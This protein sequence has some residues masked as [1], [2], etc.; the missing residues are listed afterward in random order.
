MGDTADSLLADGYATHAQLL[1]RVRADVVEADVAATRRALVEHCRMWLT[2]DPEPRLRFAAMRPEDLAGLMR[3]APRLTVLFTQAAMYPN[4]PLKRE[5]GFE[6]TSWEPVLASSRRLQLAKLLLPALPAELPVS[7]LLW[8]YELRRT[9]SALRHLKG[10]WEGLVRERLSRL[11]RCQ[12]TK[13]RPLRAGSA[14]QRFE[15]DAVVW[16]GEP[17]ANI[18]AL[19]DA[20]GRPALL[21]DIKRIEGQDFSIRA[22][23]MLA[24]AENCKAR[25]PSLPVAA[26]LYHPHLD[27][28]ERIR[29]RLTA[30][31]FDAVVFASEAPESI[32][33]ALVDVLRICAPGL[34]GAGQRPTPPARPPARTFEQG[35][36]FRRMAC[37]HK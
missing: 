22:G 18:N 29:Y 37:P 24:A 31:E 1:D 13:E 14:T 20:D 7:A 30:G 6:L 2:D 12:V 5:L 34:L 35:T 25:F 3:A 28:H 8:M 27:K 15:I 11:T 26:V 36:L 17:A 33:D 32:D 19:T 4:R 9:E 21:V 16:R 23:E 10:Q